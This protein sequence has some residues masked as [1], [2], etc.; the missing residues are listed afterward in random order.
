MTQYLICVDDGNGIERVIEHVD[1]ADQGKRYV[2]AVGIGD[3]AA[4]LE[5]PS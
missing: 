3:S 5:T 2:W 1:G 4:V